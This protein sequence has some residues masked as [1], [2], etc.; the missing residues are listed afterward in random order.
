MNIL[1]GMLGLFNKNKYQMPNVG[2][3]GAAKGDISGMAS[4]RRNQTQRRKIMRQTG[5]KQRKTWKKKWNQ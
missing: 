5:H 4:L 3:S 1:K 2:L